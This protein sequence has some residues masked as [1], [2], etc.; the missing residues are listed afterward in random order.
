MTQIN[1]VD[2]SRRSP[3][4]ENRLSK[5]SHRGFE[6]YWPLLDRS[7]VDPT[8]FERSFQRTEGLARLLILE[9]LPK[10]SDRDAYTDQRR[11]ERGRPALNRYFRN[12]RFQ[13]GNI[14]AGIDD[15]TPEWVEDEEISDYHTFSVP[16]GEKFTAKRIEKLLYA[17]DLLLNADW[18]KPKDREVNL[19]RHPAFF[20][21]AA[22]I[23]EDCCGYCPKPTNADEEEVHEEESKIYVSGKISF[24][25]DNPGRQTIGSFNPI[26]D[27][28]WTEMAYVG[29]TARLCQAIVDGDLEHVKDWLEQEG[30]DPNRRDY[31]GRTPLQLAAM[32]STPA[33]VRAL[34]NANARLTA[35][36]AD[37][38]TALH[39]AAARGDAEIV[40]VIMV[41][42]EA[43]EAEEEVK[44]LLRR[45][46]KEKAKAKNTVASSDNDMSD[47][48]SA[49]DDSDEGLHSDDAEMVDAESSEAM[50]ATSGS[51]VKLSKKTKKPEESDALPVDEDEDEPDFYDVN[52][53][54]WD[55]PCSP[56]HLAIVNGH[57]EVVKELCSTFGADVLLPVKMFNDYDHSP[58][59]AIL[60]LVLALSLPKNYAKA[61]VKTL[62]NLGASAR[63]ADF[64]GLTAFHYFVDH[65]LAAV[66][67][68]IDYDVASVKAV[69]NQL[70]LNDNWYSVRY[71]TPLLTAI[72]SQDQDRV[73][74]LLDISAKV[75]IEF[76]TFMKTAKTK[77]KT[78]VPANNND[79][80]HEKTFQNAGEQPLCLAIM[81]NL[82]EVAIRM[83]DE[84]ADPSTLSNKG[85][86]VVNETW[87]RGSN[88]GQTALDIVTEKLDELRAYKTDTSTNAVKPHP[89]QE[90]AF[91]LDG[92]QDGTYQYDSIVQQ[93]R[94]EK[95]SRK[96]EVANYESQVKA[97]ETRPGLK[98]KETAIHDM[99]PRFEA[100]HK[101]LESK[102]AKTFKDLY[103]DIQD[104]PKQTPYEWKPYQRPP[105]KVKFDFNVTGFEESLRQ[106]YIDLFE[107]A[108]NNDLKKIKRLTTQPQGKKADQPPLQIV[109]DDSAQASPFSIAVQRGHLDTALA[110]LE[111]CQSQYV[112][113]DEQKQRYR[114]ADHDEYGDSG[115]D[116]DG[117]DMDIEAMDAKDDFTIET[118][119]ENSLDVQ[120]D[121]PPLYL[122]DKLI[123][124]E[125]NSVFD[126][127]SLAIF[128]DDYDLLIWLL[129]VGQKY[130]DL[131]TKQGVEEDGP[132]FF[133]IKVN[134]LKLAIKLGRTKMLS[135][136]LSRTG[137]GIPLD[138]LVEKSGVE[139]KEKPKFYQGLSVHGKKRA[140]WAMAGR[141]MTVQKTGTA[142][143]L[144]LVAAQQG[145]LD[146]LDWFMSDAPLRCY[147]EF[148]ARYK[149]DK[150][151]RHLSE[152][153][154]GFE[155][156]IEKWLNARGYL[157]IHCA[158]M[159][160]PSNES[161]Q[162]LERLIKQMPH[163]IDKKNFEGRTPLHVAFSL[164]RIKAAQMLIEA[165]ADVMAK[166]KAFRNV[167][168]FALAPVQGALCQ[169]DRHV[170]EL[171]DLLD[172]KVRRDLFKQ[173]N[174]YAA[175]AR[176]PLHHWITCTQHN[177]AEWQ[178]KILKLWL[179]YSEGIELDMIDG[180]G[181]SP[182][183]TLIASRRQD[184]AE[185]LL[186]LRPELLVRE[187]ATGRT[188]FEIAWDNYNAQ[189]VSKDSSLAQRNRY[190]YYGQDSSVS[191]T[192]KNPQE[193]VEDESKKSGKVDPIWDLCQR[194]AKDLSAKRRLVTLNEANE[195]ARRLA[196]TKKRN[197]DEYGPAGT[198][199]KIQRTD[200]KDEDDVEMGDGT[201][202]LNG[203]GDE[204]I[205]WY[206]EAITG[207]ENDENPE[208]LDENGL[209][210]MVY[211]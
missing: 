111:I 119:G 48:D 9:K 65:S 129:D 125:S 97:N 201:V 86:R 205:A 58:R 177:K 90:D 133:S 198:R 152:T 77:F 53:L 57:N 62:L 36:M 127:F 172:P 3:S 155:R 25:R 190:H 12:S 104:P 149:H 84:G 105:F 159:A 165:G 207:E 209:P 91:Y 168:H 153:G 92:Y 109:V 79:N 94:I 161:R 49:E 8:I 73:N 89:L 132:T 47:D 120:C 139:V 208:E 67:A 99:I 21:S 85:W 14:K 44:K 87:N 210:V 170:K 107:A 134:C 112:P 147:S 18:N 29:N 156:V 175:G 203:E 138:D 1:H 163:L 59:S 167:L 52:V 42:S 130:T 40:K 182:L 179:K 26:T 95:I 39:L 123:S 128:K 200:T 88:K 20:G 202:E 150:R 55:F 27:D 196:E 145:S 83:L 102:G 32:V 158:I 189:A 122:I 46:E 74:L 41:R 108:W 70:S 131:K 38:R 61:M 199:L 66:K 136:I 206:G 197:N 171:L 45:S 93:L 157:L 160:K 28:D 15:E 54:T 117:D 19:H 106:P 72:E 7:R 126:L 17:K 176:T 22:D 110:I 16:Y 180:T 181:N 204:V 135:T 60:T 2:L 113:A 34:V 137:A 13:H 114:M 184:H 143:S 169:L 23:I 186:E 195:V 193:F 146:S 75:K 6:V 63:Q 68:L 142:H 188:P 4:Y 24:I 43:N 192:T 173:K 30:S 11:Q 148:A 115:D 76:S 81:K 116:S 164:H 37:G 178:D 98:E 140:D 187:N 124:H 118:S 78:Q 211:D 71:S 96:H 31:T 154:G 141:E 151:L 82:P 56:L 50:S 10:S 185:I 174:G 64:N 51:Y 5:Y 144:V 121:K 191:L 100:L 166:D 80:Q 194:F 162:M 69:V 101:A 35:R 33:V 183:H 103:P